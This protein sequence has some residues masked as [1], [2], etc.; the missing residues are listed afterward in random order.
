[1]NKRC[2]LTLS[3]AALA[4]CVQTRADAQAKV[5]RSAADAS[6]TSD[7][8]IIVTAQKR[9]QT[10]IDVPQSIS[11]V[12]GAS[13]DRQQA[14]TFRDY[15]KLVPGLQLNQ[16]QPGTS[17]LI[18]RGINTGGVA[19]TVAVYVD[20][21]P[22]GSSSGQVNG[23]ILASDFDTFDVARIEVLRGPQGTLYG[24]NSLGGL[25][26][27]VTNEPEL[28]KFDGKVRS[29]VETTQGGQIGYSGNAV[30]NIPIG[31]DLAFRASG[32][33]QRYGGFIDSIGTAAVIPTPTA[34]NPAATTTRVSDV[35]KDI[36]GARTY[37]GRAS[38]LFK[39]SDRFKLRLS[40]ILQNIDAGSPD[41]IESNPVTLQELFGRPTQSQF[42]PQF[43]DTI[44]RL[45]NAT[46]DLDL[47]FA[48][49]T[50]VS[51]YGTLDQ[52]IRYDQTVYLN[53]AL[54]GAFGILP[55]FSEPQLTRQ[56]KF[57]Q[58]VRLASSDSTVF[59]WLV[60]GYY[61][62][63]TGLIVQ[64]YD[65]YQPGT[66]TP[67]VGLPLLAHV[68]LPSTYSEYAG[69]ANGTVH[70]GPKVDL[71]LGG[72]YSHNQQHAGETAVGIL[73]TATGALDVFPETHSSD[74][75][76][77]FSASP[78]YK[79]SNLASVYARVAKGYRPGGPNP[80]P[81]TAV[82]VPRTYNSDSVIS[83]EAG[84]KAETAD[85]SLSID[86]AAFHIDW[87][88]IQ[89]LSIVGAFGVNTNGGK[90]QSDGG[91]FTIT[92]RP[93]RGLTFT[94][95]GAITHAR[96]K[97]DSGE[98]AGGLAGDA[99]PYTPRYSIDL[100]GQYEWAMGADI[101]PYVGASLRSL[102]KQNG[103]YDFVYRTTFGHQRQIEAYEVVDLRAGVSFGRYEVEAYAKNVNNALGR[104]SVASTAFAANDVP[105]GNLATAIIRP[106]TV[107]LSVTAGF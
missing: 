48:T 27:F 34:A 24:A 10:L 91:E 31:E 78:E 51:S 54:K 75:V 106:R 83:Y 93:T 92:A 26:K 56:H 41:T 100:D 103:D 102:S 5:Q 60:G 30:V 99:L 9:E 85:H 58:E 32:Y 97:Q 47:G 43:R 66:L 62:H 2:I 11:V 79:F 1:M 53:T 14:T 52:H 7:N 17:R 45:Y 19:S 96:L 107:G 4:L 98:L 70:L 13:L 101:K 25:L 76:F 15:L 33:Y 57:T 89:L 61:T 40:A 20:D 87:R 69:F 81:D 42:V 82:G 95:N 29:G 94:V 80:L 23:A 105:N 104:T 8:E 86:A 22:F 39:P 67:V 73:A 6:S 44:S 88:H 63:E 36:N 21:T 49:L 3:T 35:A 46:A 38:L 18:L 74:N 59:D 55:D 50:S 16:T 84:V 71:T 77:T 68:T 64:D 37:G 72:R 28:G 65:A 12:S 90:A